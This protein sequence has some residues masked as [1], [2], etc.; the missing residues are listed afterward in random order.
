MQNLV[1]CLNIPVCLNM[2]CDHTR[3]KDGWDGGSPLALLK[4]ERKGQWGTLL[5]C[6]WVGVAMENQLQTS[7]ASVMADPVRQGERKQSEGRCGVTGAQDLC[8]QHLDLCIWRVGYWCKGWAS[9]GARYLCTLFLAIEGSGSG[10]DENQARKLHVDHQEL[11]LP[12][13]GSTRVGYTDTTRF[14]NQEHISKDIL[15]F[16]GSQEVSEDWGQGESVWS[17]PTMCQTLYWVNEW[18]LVWAGTVRS[19]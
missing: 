4:E 2:L 18:I 10:R 6:K 1:K 14:G 15:C 8:H 13:L 16:W 7:C 17:V 12:S 19:P 9:L 5:L 11:Q 3:S